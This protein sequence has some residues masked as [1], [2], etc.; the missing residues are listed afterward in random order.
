MRT[1][2]IDKKSGMPINWPAAYD[3][4]FPTIN[5]FTRMFLSSILSDFL[6]MPHL[7]Q[8]LFPLVSRHFTALPFFTTWHLSSFCLVS[9][10]FTEL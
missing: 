3:Q 10:Y 8:S 5:L 4:L 1:P 7:P 9:C 6:L 2:R